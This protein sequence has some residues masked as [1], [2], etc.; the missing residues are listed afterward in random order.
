MG[1]RSTLRIEEGVYADYKKLAR[2]HYRPGDPAVP[3]R[4]LRCVAGW[5]L[6]GVLVVSMPTLMGRWRREAWPE[7]KLSTIDRSASARTLNRRVR[8]IA[9]V[10]V[11]PRFRGTGVARVLVRA[12]LSDPDTTHTE[13]I[14]AMG[15]H[16][17]FFERAGMRRLNLAPVSR[18]IELAATLRDLRV[19]P[20][21]LADCWDQRPRSTRTQ[22]R[23]VRAALERWASCAQATRKLA[24][25]PAALGVAAAAALCA[26]PVVFVA[27]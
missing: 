23:R 10:I 2:W 20:W 16:S 15:R 1:A 19:A 13:A 21:E 24:T 22:S 7:L 4:V 12:Y 11:E 17:P 27:P 6:A 26:P 3:V 9:R 5:E 14:A 25:D 18:D 8:T